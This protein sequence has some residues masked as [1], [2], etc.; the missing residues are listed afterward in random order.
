MVENNMKYKVSIA[1]LG[2][3]L[4]QMAIFVFISLNIR[5]YER[6]DITGMNKISLQSMVVILLVLFIFCIF[7]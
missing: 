3:A 7:H 5:L 2:V 6:L 4:V 1:I